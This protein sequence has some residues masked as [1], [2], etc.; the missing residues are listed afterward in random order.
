MTKH[1]AG[2]YGRTIGLRERKA[3]WPAP[4]TAW[5][6]LC[7]RSHR[8]SEACAAERQQPVLAEAHGLVTRPRRSVA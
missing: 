1:T 5:C 2:K 6:Y 8:W 3:G 4:V 7:S